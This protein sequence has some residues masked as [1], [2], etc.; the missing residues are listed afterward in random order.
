M[1]ND[2]SSATAR[3]MSDRR[4]NERQTRRIGSARFM[5]GALTY[6][7][8]RIFSTTVTYLAQLKVWALNCARPLVVSW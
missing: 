7:V 2:I 8:C 1:W 6:A 5:T 3:R 4:S